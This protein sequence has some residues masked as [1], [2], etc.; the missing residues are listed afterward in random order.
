MQTFVINKPNFLRELNDYFSIAVGLL[1]YAVGWTCFM[2]P[3]QITLG[4]ST[5]I[6]AI[7]FYATGIPMHVTYLIINA[8]LLVVALIILGWKFCAKTI[9]AV[10]LLTVFLDVGQELMKNDAGAMIQVLGEGQDFMACVVGACLCGLGVGLVFSYNGS[11]GGTDV[12]AAI[13]NKYRSVSFGR[14]IMYSDF[15]I[16][17][18][19][20]FVFHDWRRVLFGYVALLI[21]S[22]TLDFFMNNTRGSAQFFIFSNKYEEIADVI[23]SKLH[24]GVTVL[25]GTGWYSKQTRKVLIVM[26]RRQDSVNIFRIIR[27]IDPQA[28]VSQ[29]NVVGVYGEGFD[30]MKG[31]K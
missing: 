8:V 19:C 22:F 2:L 24:R 15:L 21:M 10:F 23:N 4:G 20:Y 7:V 14:G 31:K 17:S 5:G 26:A 12:I 6:S 28:F 25:D 3:Y 11:T 9:Y 30:K 27:D 1:L 16:I 29:A 18:S 13:I